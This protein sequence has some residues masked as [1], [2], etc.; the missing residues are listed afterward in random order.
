VRWRAFL[1]LLV[2][3]VAGCAN[4]VPLIPSTPTPVPPDVVVVASSGGR[5]PTKPAPRTPEPT[6]TTDLALLIRTVQPFPT[7]TPAPPATDTPTVVPAYTSTPRPTP[8]RPSSSF[9]QAPSFIT[10]TVGPT[11]TPPPR[12]SPFPRPELTETALARTETEEP[13]DPYEPNDTPGQAAPLSA[14]PL[15]AAINVPNDVDVFVVDV[16]QTDVVLV[17]TLN[18]SQAGRYKVDVIA[19]RRGKVGRQRLDGTVTVRA[20]ADVGS[21]TGLYYV[22]VQRSGALTPNGQ[23]VIS[24]D[25]T[26]PAVTPTPTEAG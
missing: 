24:A 3:L 5:L 10:P 2:V 15:D 11:R 22:Y 26:S 7:R 19:P 17:V 20:L 25:F 1:V 9:P 4:P 13:Y 16:T 23:Y 8:T 6:P 12:F 14:T 18:A 21:E